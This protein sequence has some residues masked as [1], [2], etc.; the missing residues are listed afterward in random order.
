MSS[1]SQQAANATTNTGQ[2]GLNGT[3]RAEQDASGAIQTSQAYKDQAVETYDGL[4]S[5]G[6]VWT[7]QAIDVPFS[8]IQYRTNS[9]LCRS[10][11]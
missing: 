5:S 4:T 8:N 11:Y 3:E 10:K 9:N 7:P 6:K 2:S 1:S